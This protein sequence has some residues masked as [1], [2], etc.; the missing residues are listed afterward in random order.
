[1][2]TKENSIRTL[3]VFIPKVDKTVGSLFMTTAKDMLGHINVGELKNGLSGLKYFGQLTLLQRIKFNNFCD[4]HN[5][6]CI[7]LEYDAEM[8]NKVSDLCIATYEK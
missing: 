6:D 1:M 5:T 7:Y 3:I 8:E 4:V 2:E